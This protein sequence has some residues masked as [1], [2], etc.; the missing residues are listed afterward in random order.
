M[1][2]IEIPT[3]RYALMHLVCGDNFGIMV[4]KFIIV[5]KRRIIYRAIQIMLV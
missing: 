5:L 1:I 4:I 2:E 3:N